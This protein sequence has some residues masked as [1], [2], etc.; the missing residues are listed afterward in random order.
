MQ[1]ASNGP[2]PRFPGPPTRRLSSP[3]PLMERFMPV[4]GDGATEASM[5]DIDPASSAN[6]AA[7]RARAD[8]ITAIVLVLL[9][10]AVTYASWT[11]DRLEVRRIHPS[12]IPGL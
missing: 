8:L 6:E 12:T 7:I 10:L 2:L 1:G 11:M 5:S 9:G 4:P 3:P